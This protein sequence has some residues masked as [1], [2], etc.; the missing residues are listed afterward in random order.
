MSDKIKLIWNAERKRYEEPLPPEIIIHDPKRGKSFR[1]TKRTCILCGQVFIDRYV[2]EK[3]QEKNRY[4]E[5]T[6][7]LTDGRVKSFVFCEECLD[8][9]FYNVFL[10]CKSKYEEENHGKRK[11][12]R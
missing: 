1:E 11:N 4:V 9:V 10:R 7:N 3:L 12:R 8:E 6:R 2:D 5:Y